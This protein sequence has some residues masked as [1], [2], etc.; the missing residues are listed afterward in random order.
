M[1][2][3]PNCIVPNEALIDTDG[4]DCAAAGLTSGTP[5][6]STVSPDPVVLAMTALLCDVMETTN[7]P[8]DFVHPADSQGANGPVRGNNPDEVTLPV[9]PMTLITGVQDAKSGTLKVK[10]TVMVLLSQGY[11]DD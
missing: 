8:V 10:L 4:D 1:S 9:N 2:T 3:C 7:M 11:G 5:N 6:T